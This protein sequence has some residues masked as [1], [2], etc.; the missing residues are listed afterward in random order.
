MLPILRVQDS[1]DRFNFIRKAF[2]PSQPHQQNPSNCTRKTFFIFLRRLLW[3][4]QCF[5][6]LSFNCQGL[7]KVA[8]LQLSNITDST[9]VIVLG[10]HRACIL[11]YNTKCHLIG[12]SSTQKRTDLLWKVKI[13]SCYSGFL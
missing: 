11:T 1:L 2:Y 6:N 10:F 5:S 3:I 13:S 7:S 8:Y 12:I 4:L 9:R